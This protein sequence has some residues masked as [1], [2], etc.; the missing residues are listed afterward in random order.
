MNRA[1]D[2]D[3]P[4]EGGGPPADE[5]PNSGRRPYVPPRLEILGDLRDLTMGPSPGIG[6]SAGSENRQPPDF[7]F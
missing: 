5:R 1:S 3:R 2:P 6:D 4:A 7:Q